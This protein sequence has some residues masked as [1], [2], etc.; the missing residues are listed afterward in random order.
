[1]DIYDYNNLSL[2][3]KSSLL[4]Q[5]AQFIDRY[6]E[7]D[8]TSCLYHINNFFIEAVVSHREN[9]IVEVTPFKLSERL[10][11]Y[12]GSIDLRQLPGC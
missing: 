8:L 3:E 1:M 10:D 9:R 11:K 4:W 6:A 2:G 5:Q 7:G 12:L